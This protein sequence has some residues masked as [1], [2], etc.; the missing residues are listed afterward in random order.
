MACARDNQ[1]V[2][3]AQ[4][5]ERGLPPEPPA[6]PNQFAQGRHYNWRERFQ[7]RAILA[8]GACSIFIL[9]LMDRIRVLY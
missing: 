1:M 9:N 4:R 2:I 6:N 8:L 7:V 3:N 5:Y